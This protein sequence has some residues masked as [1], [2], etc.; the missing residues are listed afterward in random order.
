MLS[1]GYLARK[2]SV[3]AITLY[4][5]FLNRIHITALSKSLLFCLHRHPV[6]GLMPAARHAAS[7][8]TPLFIR[9]R[10]SSIVIHCFLPKSPYIFL[11]NLAFFRFLFGSH[12]LFDLD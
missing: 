7:K 2:R 10:I 11:K 1:I 6:A 3:L 5:C 4:A 9:S 8:R 12:F